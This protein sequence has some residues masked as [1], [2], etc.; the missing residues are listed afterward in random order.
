MTISS[1]NRIK[2]IAI[3]LKANNNLITTIYKNSGLVVGNEL[4]AEHTIINFNCFIKNLRAFALINSLAEISLPNFTLDDSETDKLYK[5]LNA[6]W[7]SP[8]KQL[9]LYISNQAI[10]SEYGE[11]WYK[12][13]SISL[14]NPSGYPY[15]IYNLMDLYT[16]SLAIELG[17]NGKIGVQVEDVGSGLLR[18]DDEVTVHGSFLE[19]IFVKSPD[20]KPVNIIT[21]TTPTTPTTPT[22]DALPVS[23]LFRI[24]AI[25]LQLANNQFLTTWTQTTTSDLVVS[26]EVQIHQPIYKTNIVNGKSAIYFDGSNKFLNIET[27]SNSSVPPQ[28]FPID[29]DSVMFI[30]SKFNDPTTCVFSQLSQDPS[31]IKNISIYGGKVVKGYLDEYGNYTE[32]LY[33]YP[34]IDGFSIIAIS[35]RQGANNVYINGIDTEYST[36]IQFYDNTYAENTYLGSKD[37]N[38]D[39]FNG[40]I[41]D[42]AVI[43]SADVADINAIGNFYKNLYNLNWTDIWTY[44]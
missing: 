13:G 7:G 11:N 44:A 41:A 5:T 26:Q 32:F 25:S 15:R 28:L 10:T 9:T 39:F 22:I 21:G 36:S 24:A 14:L 29:S 23:E 19:E 34:L 31:Q 38:T 43:Q 17:E 12:V 6:E 2:T 3:K 35:K 18:E 40:Y 4:I 8:R 33:N 30:V 42:M 16:D 1:V 20:P 27:A 37:P